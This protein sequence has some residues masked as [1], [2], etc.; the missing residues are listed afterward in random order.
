M[1]FVDSGCYA[2][3]VLSDTYGYRNTYTAVKYFKDYHPHDVPE[4][5]LTQIPRLRVLLLGVENV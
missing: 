3:W 5:M 2:V 1:Y 4:N